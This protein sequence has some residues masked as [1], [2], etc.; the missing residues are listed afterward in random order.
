[1]T[2]KCVLILEKYSFGFFQPPLYYRGDARYGSKASI[3]LTILFALFMIIGTFNIVLSIFKREHFNLIQKYVDFFD[4][5]ELGDM[6]LYKAIM[7]LNPTITIAVKSNIEIDC[8]QYSLAIYQILI[9][10]QNIEEVHL[11]NFDF[12]SQLQ[13]G[14]DQKIHE[15]EIN[16]ISQKAYIDYLNTTASAY[17]AFSQSSDGRVLLNNYFNVY[18][19][20]KELELHGQR[21]EFQ[22]VQLIDGGKVI[23][24][25][26]TKQAINSNGKLQPESESHFL[27]TMNIAQFNVTTG[28]L[29]KAFEFAGIADE[30]RQD[31]YIDL[32][33]IDY[34]EIARQ[35]RKQDYWYYDM[36]HYF[37]FNRRIVQSEMAPDSIFS[38]LAQIGGLTGLAMIFK[39]VSAYQEKNFENEIKKN[40]GGNQGLKSNLLKTQRSRKGRQSFWRRITQIRRPTA[41]NEEIQ[42]EI[43]EERD[44]EGGH[45][46]AQ[47]TLKVKEFFSIEMFKAMHDNI[48]ELKEKCI[49]YEKEITMLKGYKDF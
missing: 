24:K 16:L 47:E 25:T 46:D 34:Y 21:I 40:Q 44:I 2:N 33:D 13:Q 3:V 1:M 29:S 20:E 14:Q 23:N 30:Y 15:C 12:E 6:K 7:M 36:Y 48:V 41:I 38:G 45:E 35:N 8:S 43:L 31:S 26:T 28:I 10:D 22:S 11:G 42:D 9:S 17:P 4:V 39:F 49:G 32:E 5:P 37:I 27:W 19:T 18:T